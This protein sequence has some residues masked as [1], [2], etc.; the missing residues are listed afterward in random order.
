MMAVEKTLTENQDADR[1]LFL[2]DTFEGMT[3]PGAV[4]RDLQGEPA[5]ST[6]HGDKIS[7]PGWCYA[8]LE[9]VQ[10]AM[11]QSGYDPART[12]F[13]KG[14]VEQTLPARAPDRIALLRLD[15]D[16]YE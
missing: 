10:S 6:L 11:R 15:T 4:D 9:D 1:A 13:V 14:A 16:W 12:V 8:S 5:A 3:E 7:N 2:F